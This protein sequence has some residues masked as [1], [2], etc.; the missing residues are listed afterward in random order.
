MLTHDIEPAVDVVKGTAR[1]FAGSQPQAT[2]LSSKQNIVSE[3]AITK[4]D[5]QTFAQICNKIVLSEA[6][7]LIKAIYLRRHFEITDDVGLE[8]NLLASLLHKREV[9]TIKSDTE[10]REMSA[11][12]KGDAEATI[13]NTKIA[14][15]EYNGLLSE[16]NDAEIMMTKYNATDVG[17]EKIQLFRLIKGKHEDDIISKFINESYHIENEYVMQLD[18]RRFDSIPEYVVKECDRLLAEDWTTRASDG[19]YR[20][21]CGET[22][23]ERL[24]EFFAASLVSWTTFAWTE[25]C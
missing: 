11:A 19:L 23:N 8:Y 2:F 25:S 20:V 14:D 4:P 22:Q 21:S 16:L 9:P 5:I 6:D 10:D 1:L 18:P 15:F 3:V 12:E 13:K 17:Y 24:S 7:N